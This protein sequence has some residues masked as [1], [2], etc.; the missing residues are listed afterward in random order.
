MSPSQK[1]ALAK[2][3]LEKGI[4]TEND[5]PA[6]FALFKLSR[7][8]ATLAT[9]CATA[10]G[11]IDELN[12]SFQIDALEMKTT[13]L[14]KLT[15]LARSAKQHKAIAE[16]T[17]ELLQ[18][19][20]AKDNFTLAKQLAHLALGE[21][22][23]AKDKSLVARLEERSGEINKAALAFQAA[24]QAMATLEKSPADAEANLVAGKYKCFVKVDWDSGIPMLAMGSDEA[25]KALAMQEL[26]GA[27]SSHEQAALGDHWWDLAEKQEGA[28]KKQIQGRAGYWYE[29]ALPGLSGLM[30]DKA[31][32]RLEESRK[33]DEKE[34]ALAGPRSTW[35]L[36]FRSSD[37]AVWNTRSADRKRFAIPL[38]SVPDDIRFLKVQIEPKKLV[39]LAITKDKLATVSK[40]GK[41]G[42]EGRNAVVWGGRQLGVFDSVT[43]RNSSDVCMWYN[44]GGFSGWGFGFREGVNDQG[45][46]WE[47]RPIGRTTFEIYVKSGDLVPMERQYLL[48]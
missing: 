5:L 12:Q 41:Y 4:E 34:T 3:L 10:F 33:V 21:A 13:V 15:S 22:T 36:I 46:A 29:K 40:Q 19:A 16:K 17:A 32:K 8:I 7:D 27:A 35:L 30:K 48:R 24:S 2:K 37:P 1:Q 44:N 14:T 47:G 42:W 6:R 9:D 11:A 20:V 28:V 45:F 18:A 43:P 31:E 25:L 26:K 23:K 39:V 38:A